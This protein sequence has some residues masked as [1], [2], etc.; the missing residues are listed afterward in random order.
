MDS[1]ATMAKLKAENEELKHQIKRRNQDLFEALG[2]LSSM[3]NQYCPPPRTHL[4]MSAGEEA[5]EVLQKWQLMRAD[6]TS[7]YIDG[8]VIDDDIPDVVLGL[9]NLD[10]LSE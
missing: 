7:I 8:M 4:N 9:R 6:E 1:E 10:L 2:A 5:E 3:W